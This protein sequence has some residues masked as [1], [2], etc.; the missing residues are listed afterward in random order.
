MNILFR[1][2]KPQFFFIVRKKNVKTAKINVDR[3]KVHFKK[4][5]KTLFNISI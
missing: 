1:M 4:V 3:K 5:N 2:K